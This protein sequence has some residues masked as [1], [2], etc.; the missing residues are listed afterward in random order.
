MTGKY[1]TF[2]CIGL[3]FCTANAIAAQNK[4]AP[5][6]TK[7]NISVAAQKGLD[8][9]NISASDLAQIEAEAQ[10][11]SQEGKRMEQE[12]GKI[13][14]E[15]NVVNQKMLNVSKK[16]QSGQQE[17]TKKKDELTLLQ[18]HLQESESKF[19]SEYGMLVETLSAL[20]TLALRPSE[21]VL[22]QPLSPVD[23]MRSSILLRGSI[24]SLENRAA[25]IRRS[26]EDIN[27]QKEEIA[28]R[29]SDIENQNKLLAQQQDE[30]K[31]LSKQKS[32]MY[33]QL[34]T[35]SQEAKQKA[36]LLAGQAKDI[37]DLLEKLEQQRRLKEQQ[38]EKERIAKAQAVEKLREQNNHS[39]SRADLQEQSAQKKPSPQSVTNF[40]KARGQLTRP[41]AGQLVTSFHQELSKGVLSN[42]IDIKTSSKAQVI[43]PFDGTVIFAG[44]FKNFANLVIIDH[45]EGYTSLLSGMEETYTEVGQLLVVGEPV[46]VMPSHDHAK[47]HMEIRKNSQPINPNEWLSTK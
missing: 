41:V 30:M 37:R 32:E 10:K 46:G 38:A 28:Q 39:L 15:L 40:S 47:L 20:Q 12:A 13:K 44:P 33:D 6:P 3:Y 7:K 16:I 22:I 25:S 45:G 2:F 17:L 31:L 18:K 35:Q 42:G 21:A 11:V 9:K 8:Q 1:I 19:D 36:R 43:A 4:S 24:H 14:A 26:I 29:L 27:S 34:S 5:L 23:V